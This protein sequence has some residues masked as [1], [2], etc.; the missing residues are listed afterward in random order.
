MDILDSTVVQGHKVFLSSCWSLKMNTTQHCISTQILNFK[1]HRSIKR[2]LLHVFARRITLPFVHLLWK[3]V[4]LPSTSHFFLLCGFQVQAQLEKV[5]AELEMQSQQTA[6]LESSCRALERSLGQSGKRLQVSSDFTAHYLYLSIYFSK[7]QRSS[8]I[9]P[10]FGS[11]LEMW[12][13][14]W[15]IWWMQKKLK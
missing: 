4:L 11:L 13:P 8:E 2:V 3:K 7:P 1:I 12:H 10:V 9:W 5:R 14:Q 6:R 15:C